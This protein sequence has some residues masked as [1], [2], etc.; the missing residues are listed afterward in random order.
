MHHPNNCFCHK[1]VGV[2]YV[3]DLALYLG[4][5]CAEMMHSVSYD[6]NDT[7]P[8]NGNATSAERGSRSASGTAY[9]PAP[10]ANPSMGTS[11][12]SN[13]SR[14]NPRIGDITEEDRAIIIARQSLG[15]R[16]VGSLLLTVTDTGAGTVFEEGVQ[17]NSQQLQG[18]AAA[19]LAWRYA[20]DWWSNTVA[21]SHQNLRAWVEAARSR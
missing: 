17:F 5:W 16:E 21:S 1:L 18:E 4:V 15:L 6:A 9:G 11:G 12:S 10:A 7:N 2:L 3:T 14:C 20:K 19:A 8:E 13:S